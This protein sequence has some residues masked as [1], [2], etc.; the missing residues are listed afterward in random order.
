M[1][2]M[3]LNLFV[4]TNVT[5]IKSAVNSIRRLTNGNLFEGIS[6]F[7][8]PICDQFHYYLWELNLAKNERYII[9]GFNM[10]SG[11]KSM[12]KEY[13]QRALA[14]IIFCQKLVTQYHNLKPIYQKLSA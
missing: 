14:L 8:V 2:L 7:L 1:N 5:A 6:M 12:M 10:D 11:Y 9:D 4:T 3:V 13:M